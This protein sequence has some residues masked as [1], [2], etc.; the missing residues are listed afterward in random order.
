MSILYRELLYGLIVEY[1]APFSKQKS[2]KQ[3]YISEWDIY[4]QDC[5]INSMVMGAWLS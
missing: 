5:E 4:K 2:L 1:L 3:S